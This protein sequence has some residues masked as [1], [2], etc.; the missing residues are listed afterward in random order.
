VRDGI[1]LTKA[2]HPTAVIVQDSF[3]RAARAQAA[4]LGMPDLK[5]YV[6]PQHKA[7]HLG[8]EETKKGVKAAGELRL[9]LENR[10]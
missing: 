1:S 2:G 5:I 4:A 6:Y 3:E 10:R 7:G 9:L 8:A